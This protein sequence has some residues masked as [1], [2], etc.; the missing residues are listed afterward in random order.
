MN[1]SPTKAIPTTIG[2]L[3]GR[4][5]IV[6]GIMAS[7][8]LGIVGCG[9]SSHPSAS[10]PQSGSPVIVG[11]ETNSLPKPP[12]QT[13]VNSYAGLDVQAN[14]DMTFHI[15]HPDKSYYYQ[16]PGY[17]SYNNE[18]SNGGVFSSLADFEY[19]TE[20][21]VRNSQFTLAGF[22][23]EIEGGVAL[24]Q[25]DNQNAPGDLLLGVP[26]QL[27]GCI[28]PKG[29]IGFNFLHVPA[30]QSH[31]AAATD[32][33]YGNAGLTY[34]DGMF[35]YSTVQQF[36]SGGANASTNTIPFA[37]SY[38]IS[39]PEGY[40]I[41]SA[42]TSVPGSIGSVLV[43]LSATGALI[44]EIDGAGKTV[45]GDFIGMVQPSAAIDLS[46]VTKGSYKGFYLSQGPLAPGNPAYFGQT[47]AWITTPVFN[48][49]G[50]SMIGGNESVFNLIF[51]PVAAIP[52]NTLIDF[53]TQD[54]SHPGLFPSATIEEPDPSNL[55]P[56]KQQSI[57][58]DGN[59]YCTFPVA[60][61]IGESYGKYAIFIAG[62]EPTVGFPLFYALVQ[63]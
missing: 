18:I 60:A 23:A 40:G 51:G 27:S 43:Y 16:Q 53:G 2:R 55:C 61:L 52:G 7:C 41:Q 3:C 57:G 31:Y 42:E 4:P 1:S 45:N 25:E 5:I 62:P 14:I 30:P 9:S 38:C 54:S 49:T 20:N 58:S 10:T 19:L 29:S 21:D 48:Q 63:D 47:S 39:A 22:S 50:T 33:L 26:E 8:A 6:A 35:S 56:A 24:L 36:A 34:A 37:N 32:T 12:A 15:S 17:S 28:A 59:T 46:A 11:T 44:G 13:D